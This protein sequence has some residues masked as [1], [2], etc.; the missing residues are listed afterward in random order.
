MSKKAIYR[1]KI[2]DYEL[3]IKEA[4]ITLKTDNKIDL[5]EVLKK[6]EMV[7]FYKSRLSKKE[8]KQIKREYEDEERFKYWW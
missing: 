2:E 7:G 4:L 3:D 8:R 6:S 1:R 5:E